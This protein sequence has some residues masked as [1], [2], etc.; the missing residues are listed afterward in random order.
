[1][2]QA[3]CFESASGRAIIQCTA[4]VCS[5]RLVHSPNRMGIRSTAAGEV[6]RPLVAKVAQKLSIQ[7]ADASAERWRQGNSH[8]YCAVYSLCN[9]KAVSANTVLMP[10]SFSLTRTFQQCPPSKQLIRDTGRYTNKLASQSLDLWQLGVMLQCRMM[11]K[12]E[13]L[14]ILAHCP[15]HAPLFLDLRRPRYDVFFFVLHSL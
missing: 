10:L 6:L 8:I 13:R 5:A 14:F 15:P 1:M 2:H 9:A 4:L 11:V 12:C 7:K 3:V